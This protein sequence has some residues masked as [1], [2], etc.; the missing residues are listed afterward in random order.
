MSCVCLQR[1]FFVST[2]QVNAFSYACPPFFSYYFLKTKDVILIMIYFPPSS[3][4]KLKQQLY[5]EL[6]LYHL[7]FARSEAIP[8][9]QLQ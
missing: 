2:M 6:K 5:C 4:T 1:C 8:L 9:E 3:Q 7:D